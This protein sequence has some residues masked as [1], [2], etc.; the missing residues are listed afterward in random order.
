MKKATCFKYGKIGRVEDQSSDRDSYERI[1]Q[2]HQSYNIGSRGQTKENKECASKFRIW[3]DGDWD[4][5]HTVKIYR[6][7]RNWIIRYMKD[8]R[9][10]FWEMQLK[11]SFPTKIFL[12]KWLLNQTVDYFHVCIIG[13]LYLIF[14]RYSRFR[15]PSL[16]SR[17]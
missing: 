9:K 7:L 2:I 10:Y 16:K 3:S 13:F 12:F 1:C 14:N 17:F 5:E 15:T 4:K 11:F 6:E 8:V